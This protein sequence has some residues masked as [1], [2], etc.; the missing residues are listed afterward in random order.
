MATVH[1][2]SISIRSKAQLMDKFF[3]KKCN[4]YNT[5]LDGASKCEER[6]SLSLAHHP[7]NSSSKAS[8]TLLP[9]CSFATGEVT[10]PKSISCNWCCHLTML[11][12]QHG[13]TRCFPLPLNCRSDDHWYQPQWQDSSVHLPW[14]EGLQGA[15]CAHTQR[16][17]TTL[18]GTRSAFHHKK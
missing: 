9:S 10:A 3:S 7:S 17:A 5:Y 2:T 13:S 15:W 6:H 8:H 12:H 14:P 1:K 16:S 11:A 18:L 4:S